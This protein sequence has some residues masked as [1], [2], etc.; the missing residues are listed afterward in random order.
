MIQRVSLSY[1]FW[2]LYTHLAQ[3]AWKVPQ[4]L[5]NLPK[6]AFHP[7]PL[8]VEGPSS[9]QLRLLQYDYK[10]LELTQS[11]VHLPPI[12]SSPRLPILHL[13]LQFNIK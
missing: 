5:L 8:L 3:T 4:V 9:T 2:S 10:F 6:L 1:E 12:E 11:L 13:I 7:P